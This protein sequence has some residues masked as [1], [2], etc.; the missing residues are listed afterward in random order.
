MRL[1]RNETMILHCDNIT[2]I[3][4]ANNSILFDRT[5]HVEV[6]RFFIKEKLDSGILRL[7]YVKS[8]SQLA[9]C[10]TEGL[11]PSENELSCNK[12]AMLDIFCPS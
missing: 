9:D 5:K 1:L 10:F 2:A 3:N 12:M 11:G 4:I 8:R 6:D 7:G